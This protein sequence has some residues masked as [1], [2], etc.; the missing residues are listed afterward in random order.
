M[1]LKWLAE[2]KRYGSPVDGEAFQD[3][4]YND[5]DTATL[6]ASRIWQLCGVAQNVVFISVG[7][8]TSQGFETRRHSGTRHLQTQPHVETFTFHNLARRRVAAGDGA[9]WLGRAEYLATLRAMKEYESCVESPVVVFRW[10]LLTTR[11]ECNAFGD[12]EYRA[13]ALASEDTRHMD[14]VMEVWTKHG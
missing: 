1:S 5:C 4:L 10:L 12:E 9:G 6:P 8:N 14:F 3:M 7:T 13:K 2:E 11:L